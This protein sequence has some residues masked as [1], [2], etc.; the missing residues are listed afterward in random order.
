MTTD[1]DGGRVYGGQFQPNEHNNPRTIIA[2]W[3]PA[4]ARVLE[5]GPG[6]GVVGTWLTTHKGCRVIGVEYVAAAAAVAAATFEHMIIG[7]IEDGQV[8]DQVRSLAPYDVIIFADVLEHL[9]DP[10]G[11][12]CAL[13]PLLNPGGRVLIS[14]PNIAH[15][16]ARLN[17]LL[18]RFDYTEGYLMDRTHLR[19]FTWKSARELAARSGYRIVEEQVVFK[20]RFARFW[21]TF[22]GFQIVLNLVPDPAHEGVR[23][24]PDGERARAGGVNAERDAGA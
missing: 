8:Q 20:P 4:G 3:V 23:T 12:L 21:R 24:T 11:V 13:R 22:N 2:R 15:W 17:L 16:T 14:V 7:S 10:W 1:S 9:V 6:D 18:G 5:V 19:W